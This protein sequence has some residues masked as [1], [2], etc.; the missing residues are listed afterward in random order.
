MQQTDCNSLLEKAGYFWHQS[1]LSE[2]ILRCFE[3]VCPLN[4]LPG[5]RLNLTPKLRDIL[6]PG[7]KLSI[8]AHQHLP[9]ATAVRVI[10]FN[11]ME[12]ANWSVPW[13]QDRVVAVRSKNEVAG[14]KNWSKKK[15]VWH[16]E[17][18]TSFLRSMIFARAHLDDADEENG[19]LEVACGTH[20]LGRI[21]A[22]D[23]EQTAQQSE[24]GI[25]RA[26]RG[27]V[28]F[29]SALALHRSKSSNNNSARRTIRIDYSA[30]ALP[31]PLE[32]AFN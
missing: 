6:A 17:P 5:E 26:S 11:K 10:A 23:A 29:V 25:C 16:V 12:T 15:E 2:D 3:H 18:P 22:A 21:N 8:L 13:H 31:E 32:W 30:N 20:Q 28:L 1:A 9:G 19:C 7:A 14:F 4:N 24:I 27:D